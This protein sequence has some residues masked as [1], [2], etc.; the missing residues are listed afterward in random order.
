[1]HDL[2]GVRMVRAAMQGGAYG[3]ALFVY[4]FAL[5]LAGVHVACAPVKKAMVEPTVTFALMQRYI[6]TGRCA[7]HHCCIP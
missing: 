7:Y 5:G 2:V 6:R 4:R 3:H 1:M